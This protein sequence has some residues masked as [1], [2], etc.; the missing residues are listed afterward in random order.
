MTDRLLMADVFPPG[1]PPES[2]P[3]VLRSGLRWTALVLEDGTEIVVS[4]S[5]LAAALVPAVASRK[6]A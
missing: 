4:T 2:E 3:V 6:A 5:E 1:E